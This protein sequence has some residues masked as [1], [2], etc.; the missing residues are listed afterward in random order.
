MLQHTHT[1][2]KYG[3]HS[4][5]AYSQHIWVFF[6][7]KPNVIT[8]WFHLC[9]LMTKARRILLCLNINIYEHVLDSV[10][11]PI[12]CYLLLWS[13]AQ[14]MLHDD[15]DALF[16]HLDLNSVI[17]LDMKLKTIRLKIHICHSWPNI[18][19]QISRLVCLDLEIEIR[20]WVLNILSN[21]APPSASQ[22]E[23]PRPTI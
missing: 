10:P 22:T 17:M 15:T 19:C 23:D 6:S 21:V 1:L 16:Y 9:I 14:R 8:S 13:D 5:S 20:I 2:V 18:L 11:T 12:C 3:M 4:H 7:G